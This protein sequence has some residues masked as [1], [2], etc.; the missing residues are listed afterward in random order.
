MQ[1]PTVHNNGS[2]PEKLISDLFNASGKL[3][4]AIDFV[5]RC[6]A[7]ARDYYN[8]QPVEN[9]SKASAE[10]SE[11][12]QALIKVR[13]ELIALAENVQRQVIE[14][15]RAREEHRALMK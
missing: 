12:V 14:R 10:H 9:F 6:S 15:E 7:H 1:Y 13:G 3:H 4:E 2:D 8:Q 11:R 5:E